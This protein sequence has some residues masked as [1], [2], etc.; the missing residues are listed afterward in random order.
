M[1]W[2]KVPAAWLLDTAKTIVE[3]HNGEERRQ[4]CEDA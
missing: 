2:F 1:E 3:D 4:A